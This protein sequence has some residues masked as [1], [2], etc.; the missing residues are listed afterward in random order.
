[1]AAYGIMRYNIR[2]KK[3]IQ[4]Y[5]LLPFIVPLV[6]SGMV[7]YII[8]IQIGLI[9]NT[10]IVGFTLA[11]V[12]FPL[13]F[14]TISSSVNS[15]DPTLEYAAKNLGAEELQTFLFVT[16][17][18]IAP[19]IVSGSLLVFII[20]MNEFVVSLFVTTPS[21][22]T[23]PVMLYNSIKESISPFLSAVSVI[24]IVLACLAIAV[25]DRYIGLERFFHS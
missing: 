12:M 1:M 5:F 10:S 21:T 9:G 3:P 19:G 2:L 18:L 4:A 23:L 7:L 24:Y 16:L 15:L 25:F 17:P 13:M 14:W 11:L 22:V 8:Y 6:A 20:C